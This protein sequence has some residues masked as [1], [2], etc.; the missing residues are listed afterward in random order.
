[1][2]PAQ[3]ALDIDPA[4]LTPQMLIKVYRVEKVHAN[5]RFTLKEIRQ[6]RRGHVAFGNEVM[7]EEEEEE[8]EEEEQKEVDQAEMVADQW[9][10]V[11]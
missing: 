1:M 3:K 4:T 6:T 7:T 11:R 2:T 8:E 5:S 10:L 9:R